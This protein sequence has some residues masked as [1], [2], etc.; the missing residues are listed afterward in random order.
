[1]G[2]EKEEVTEA[3]GGLMMK[4]ECHAFGFF[5]H[6]KGGLCLSSFLLEFF[7]AVFFLFIYIYFLFSLYQAFFFV[8]PSRVFVS[9]V[10]CDGKN[11]LSSF[12]LWIHDRWCFN[13]QPVHTSCFLVCCS[14]CLVY[15]M[16]VDGLWT[17]WWGLGLD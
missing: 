2:V 1:M 16:M 10:S 6:E 9:C 11:I 15:A 13:I 3:W 12:S 5:F 7:L 4:Y 17:D 8:C 14:F